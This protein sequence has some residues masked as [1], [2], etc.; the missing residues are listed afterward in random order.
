MASYTDQSDIEFQVHP[1]VGE[2]NSLTH[3][4][5][6]AKMYGRIP[7]VFRNCVKNFRVLPGNYFVLLNVRI[8]IIFEDYMRGYLLLTN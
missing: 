2:A 7:S 3:S 1:D 8:F 6:L 4:T 5:W